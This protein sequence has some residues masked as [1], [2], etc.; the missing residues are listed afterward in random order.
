MKKKTSKKK[1]KAGDKGLDLKAD[2]FA[3]IAGGV[4]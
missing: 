3:S 1:A 4:A 2:T